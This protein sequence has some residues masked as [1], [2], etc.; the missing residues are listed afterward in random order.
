MSQV[1]TI[2]STPRDRA[3]EAAAR[4]I[5]EDKGDRKGIDYAGWHLEPESV[6]D[7]W[8]EDVRATI[9]AYERALGA[10]PVQPDMED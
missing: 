2:Q 1:T 10:G 4:F 6:K 5:Y 3:I 8:R 7:A 9:D